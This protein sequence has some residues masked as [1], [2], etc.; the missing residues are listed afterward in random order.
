MF[1]RFVANLLVLWGLSYTILGLKDLSLKTTFFF[2][3]TNTMLFLIFMMLFYKIMLQWLVGRSKIHFWQA[4]FYRLGIYLVS[5]IC[6]IVTCFIFH[7]RLNPFL[8]LIIEG[9]V[10]IA[11]GLG[12][13]KRRNRRGK[14]TSESD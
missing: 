13:P 2:A 14:S 4:L 9:S 7:Q 8:W 12:V 10:M 11:Q 1:I 3:M 6:F 5:F